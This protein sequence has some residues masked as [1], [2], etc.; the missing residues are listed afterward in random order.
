MSEH[1]MPGS[2]EAP[3]IWSTWCIDRLAEYERAIEHYPMTNSVSRLAYDLF[4]ALRKDDVGIDTLAALAKHLSDEGLQERVDAFANV[5]AGDAEQ[6][7]DPDS[8][9]ARFDGLT[10]EQVQTKLERTRAG[11][12]FTAHPTFSMPSELYKAIA[13]YASARDKREKTEAGKRLH[14]FP[15]RPDP[16]ISLQDEHRAVL[17]AIEN[18]KSSVR[19]FTR[20]I[21]KWTASQYPN[22]WTKLTPVPISVASWVG[23]DLDGRTDIH[24]A[25]TFRI[26]L[27][28]KA[29][30]LS[31]YADQLAAIKLGAQSELGETLVKKLSGASELAQEQAQLFSGDLDDPDQITGAANKL[32]NADPRRLVSLN[33]L[34]DQVNAL[35][36]AVEDD[37][38]RLDLCLLRAEMRNYGLGCAR[39]HLRINAAQIH[40]ALRADLGLKDGRDFVDRTTLALA[41]EKAKTVST[42]R[43]NVASIFLEQMTARRQMMLC[44]A[45]FKH[46]D[47][48]TPIRFLIAECEAP[49][50]IM[51]AVFL[52][53]LYGVDHALDI[54]PLFETPEAM[55]RGGRFVERLLMEDEF[56]TYIKARGRLAIQIGFSDS[57]RFMGQAASNMAIERLQILVARALS[58]KSI[59]DVEVLIF[60][61]HGESMGRGGFPGTLEGRLDYLITPWTRARYAH[62]GLPLNTESS[63]QG[64]DGFLHFGSRALSDATTAAICDWAFCEP[65]ADRSDLYYS[66]LNYTWDF[67]RSIKDWQVALFDREDYQTTVGAFGANLLPVTGSRKARRQ[68]GAVVTGPRALRAI[69]HNAILQQLAIPA[70]I[71]GGVGD[72][73]GV[74]AERLLSHARSSTRMDQLLTLVRAAR[75]LTSLPALRA[76]GVLFNA[77]FWISKAASE[78]DPATATSCHEI[79]A[80]LD[81]CKTFAAISKLS[82]HFAADLARLDRVLIELGGDQQPIERREARRPMHAMHALRQALIMKA[83]LLVASVPVFSGRHDISR[84]ALFEMAFAL[85]FSGLT[86]ALEEIF[87]AETAHSSALAGVEE[88]ADNLAAAAHGYPDI[89]DQII[90]PLSLIERQIKE[91]SVGISHYYKAWG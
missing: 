14:D 67:Y 39:I 60:N 28:E 31:A 86:V 69:P 5:H 66:D 89:H 71:F 19:E 87:P 78:K 75:R 40:S 3:S 22:A 47:S 90:V 12:V 46:V 65:E 1:A 70:N 24:W 20:S 72:T 37:D 34:I 83:F 38:A 73:T 33:D 53:R 49:A 57:G 18:T 68:S 11:I 7:S 13:D 15:Y 76:Y 25:E 44:S 36:D 9:F 10:F 35:C 80:E 81:A 77:S 74:E 27:E 26:R 17:S 54:S 51:G 41:A 48:D 8:L 32:T 21:L 6:R 62:E 88:E 29:R 4:E 91:I 50:T 85:D 23:Y 56:V 52:A 16:D 2:H 45:F 58:A 30:Q 59:V 64:G 63:F 82:N 42:R 43:T 84:E 61:T 55:E 79:A